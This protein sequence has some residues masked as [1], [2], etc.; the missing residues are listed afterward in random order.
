MPL[1]APADLDVLPFRLRA[2]T[3][4]GMVDQ[5]LTLFKALLP[6]AGTSLNSLSIFVVQSGGWL[7]ERLLMA[8]PSLTSTLRHIAI[9][10]HWAPLPGSLLT[11]LASCKGLASVILSGVP[12]VQVETL[13][14]GMGSPLEAFDFSLPKTPPR[15]GSIESLFERLLS[16]PGARRL[17]S[18]IATRRLDGRTG[19]TLERVEQIRSGC[20]CV[21]E[22]TTRALLPT[23]V[24]EY[25]WT[26]AS[27]DRVND[28]TCAAL[29]MPA[30]AAPLRV[31]GVGIA[32]IWRIDE[33]TFPVSILWTP[34]REQFLD[35]T[36]QSAVRLHAVGSAARSVLWHH[37]R[38]PSAVHGPLALSPAARN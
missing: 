22:A 29:R 37:R 23:Y 21:Y 14:Q 35:R 5:P 17:R 24:A 18:L 38:C 20:A 8:A 28:R 26:E 15:A 2:L 3:L 6:D 36:S 19:E 25:F 4:S 9:A 12:L 30:M 27:T 11:F 32:R 7:H 33:Y 10:T 31:R 16:Q 34:G 13:L 1:E